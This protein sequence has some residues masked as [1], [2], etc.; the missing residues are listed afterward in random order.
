MIGRTSLLVLALGLAACGPRN[1]AANTANAAAGAPA[2]GAAAGNAA[3]TPPQAGQ[4]SVALDGEGLRLVSGGSARALPFGTP[5][6]QTIAALTGALGGPATEQGTN[7]EC[8][9][10][11]V[12]YAT[13][14][15]NLN[16]VFDEDRFVG[17]D[18]R[19]GLTTMN[20]IGVGSTRAE[21]EAAFDPEIAQSSLGTEFSAAGMGGVLES[22]APT[23]RIT[24]LWAGTTCIA[25]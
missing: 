16:V 18:S 12:G 2:N 9:A 7:E 8:P 4:P 21:L 15:G 22:P 1:P 25:R 24:S 13:W 3:A 11:P 5:K 6:A 23:A 10:G 19:G 17:W 20:G 14:Q